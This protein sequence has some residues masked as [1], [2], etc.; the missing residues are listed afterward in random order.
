MSGC[1]DHDVN[2]SVENAID[3]EIA[4]VHARLEAA[5]RLVAFTFRKH[6]LGARHASVEQDLA[7]LGR[8][9]SA[10][11]SVFEIPQAAVLPYDVDGEPSAD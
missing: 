10:D 3:P 5:E 6:S 4:A 2:E 9:A 1:S 8:T 7:V 11:G